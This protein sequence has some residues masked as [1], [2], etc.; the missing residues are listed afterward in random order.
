MEGFDSPPRHC[1]L[2]GTEDISVLEAEAVTD[3][4]LQVLK[5]VLEQ[6][7][8]VSLKPTPFD[9]LYV[10]D[11]QGVRIVAIASVTPNLGTKARQNEG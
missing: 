11:M 5:L 1:S 6:S 3:G 4:E 9:L 10:A 7:A 8:R 2:L